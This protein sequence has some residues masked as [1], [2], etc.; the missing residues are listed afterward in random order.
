VVGEVSDEPLV[1]VSKAKERLYLPLI[2]Q[3]GP[4]CHSCDFYRVHLYMVFGYDQAQVLDPGS[5]KLAFFR[6]E[7]QFMFG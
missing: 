5:L 3:F 1:E 7:E 4:F 6:S 2:C